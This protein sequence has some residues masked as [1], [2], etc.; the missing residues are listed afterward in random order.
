M[1]SM[2]FYCSPVKISPNILHLLNNILYERNIFVHSLLE[3]R[4]SR[5]SN[6]LG[7][8]RGRGVAHLTKILCTVSPAQ[9]VCTGAWPTAPVWVLTRT[10][11]GKCSQQCFMSLL[12]WPPPEG[13]GSSLKHTVL[14]QRRTKRWS[15]LG[16]FFY[17]IWIESDKHIHGVS[18]R[19]NCLVVLCIF[20]F[21]SI[22]LEL[23]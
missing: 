20:L 23:I 13:N 22:N 6:V 21:A 7:F 10:V 8:G 16:T 5:V 1:R 2:E 11:K 17:I 3:S 15:S 9:F 4:P 18:V 14:C 19:G 12:A